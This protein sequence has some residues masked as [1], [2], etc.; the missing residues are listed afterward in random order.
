MIAHIRYDFNFRAAIDFQVWLSVMQ[1][2]LSP[3]ALHQRVQFFFTCKAAVV[4]T[5]FSNSVHSGNRLLNSF[6]LKLQHSAS[7]QCR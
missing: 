6:S 4:I 1:L 5:P 7:A 2:D 3:G